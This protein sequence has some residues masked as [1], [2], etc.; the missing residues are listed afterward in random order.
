MSDSI[1][2]SIE[3]TD[4]EYK[5]ILQKIKEDIKIEFLAIAQKNRKGFFISLPRALEWLRIEYTD[6]RYFRDN[7]K[8]RILDS[9]N[10]YFQCATSETDYDA[11]YIYKNNEDG[12]TRIKIPWFSDKGF[13]ELCMI[14]N[15]SPKAKLIRKY[16]LDLENEYVKMLKMEINEIKLV[17][18]KTLK[19]LKLKQEE[20]EI[21][22]KKNINIE[23]SY[24]RLNDKVLKYYTD[25]IRLVNENEYLQTIKNT[26][27]SNDEVDDPTNTLQ[28]GAYETLYGK[29]FQVILVSDN[30]VLD[31]L[32]AQYK[33]I[34]KQ[35]FYQKFGLIKY[36]FELDDC[37]QNINFQSIS[38]AWI[39]YSNDAQQ[40]Y[41][42]FI[43][44]KKYKYHDFIKNMITLYFINDQHYKEFLNKIRETK[45]ISNNISQYN[46]KYKNIIKELYVITYN[47]IISAHKDTASKIG[48]NL[49]Y[50]KK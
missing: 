27:Y 23:Q 19:Q 47:E 37:Y 33:D 13:K 18:D 41:F 48:F 7:F 6:N 32:M 11:D 35:D 16:Y 45:F 14:M 15:K 8:R 17:Q 39:K 36:N 43:K 10:Y 38:P 24:E 2:T 44:N 46:G 34:Q 4:E 42:Y 30:W 49:L 25:N 50:N 1:L 29:P 12:D 26:F 5:L 3:E 22:Q 28:I 20:S 40:Y 21:L 31:L 9:D